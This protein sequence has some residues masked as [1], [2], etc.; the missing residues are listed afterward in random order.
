MARVAYIMGQEAA[1]LAKLSK[2]LNQT[3]TLEDVAIHASTD[4]E[5]PSYYM[6]SPGTLTQQ[7]KDFK[8]RC[9]EHSNLRSSRVEKPLECTHLEGHVL[10]GSEYLTWPRIDGTEGRSS[11]PVMNIFK[12]IVPYAEQEVVS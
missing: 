1:A 10:V 8:R 5:N 3:I 7:Q 9:A 2:L 6:S 12:P 4:K 11:K